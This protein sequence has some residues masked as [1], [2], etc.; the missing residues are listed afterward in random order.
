MDIDYEGFTIRP[1][2]G[3][4]AG[5]IAF[6]TDGTTVRGSVT[7]PSEATAVDSAKRWID[8]LATLDL[9]A[10]GTGVDLGMSVMLATHYIPITDAAGAAYYLM[11]QDTEP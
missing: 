5:V 7:Q 2:P 1:R 9:P 6:I 3:G 11:A 4:P 10:I 8:A